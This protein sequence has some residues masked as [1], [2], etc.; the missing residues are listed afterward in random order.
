[1]NNN[2]YIGLMSGTSIDSI[3]A[4]AV[5]FDEGEFKLLGSYVQNI[6]KPV[7]QAILNQCQ[8]GTDSVKLYAE[9]DHQ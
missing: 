5:Y 8:P 1:M 7:K 9:T 6:P 3:D 4:A 2:I